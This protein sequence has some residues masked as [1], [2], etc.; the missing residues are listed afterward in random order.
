M[1]YNNCFGSEHAEIYYGKKNKC[2]KIPKRAKQEVIIFHILANALSSSN[3]MAE[4]CHD[5]LPAQSGNCIG[6]NSSAHNCQEMEE[7]NILSTFPF[8]F[9]FI[10]CY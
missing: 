1:V 10:L 3:C 6:R 5:F 8:Y 9:A 4:S 2:R 7:E